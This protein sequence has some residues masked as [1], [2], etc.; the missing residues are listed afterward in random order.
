MARTKG[1]KNK[2]EKDSNVVTE[3]YEQPQETQQNNEEQST[4]EKTDSGN[5]NNAQSDVWNIT[6]DTKSEQTPA[7]DATKYQTDLADID[8]IV[9][10]NAE[11][12]ENEITEKRGRKSKEEKAKVPFRISGYLF[13]YVNNNVAANLMAWFDG[14]IPAELLKLDE[15]ALQETAPIA[16]MAVKEMGLE[17]NPIAAFYILLGSNMAANLLQFKAFIKKLK[18]QNPKLDVEKAIDSFVESKK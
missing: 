4:E 11:K 3:I 15:K 12:S 1:S 17:E 18:K 8:K 14:T 2:K 9:Q 5:D 13:S 7:F 6:T 16:E 10:Q